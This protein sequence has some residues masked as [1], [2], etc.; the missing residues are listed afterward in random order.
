MKKTA[1]VMIAFVLGFHHIVMEALYL[2][3]VNPLTKYYHSYVSFYMEPLFEQHWQLFAPEPALYSLKFWT[4]CGKGKLKT[5][6]WFDPSEKYLKRHRAWRFGPNGKILYIYNGIARGY[7]NATID[8]TQELCKEGEQGS[9]TCQR[10]VRN[11]IKNN[12]YFKAGKS[13][14]IRE[15]QDY[16]SYRDNFHSFDW[17]QFQAIKIYPK[18]FSEKNSA[19]DF[20]RIEY[21]DSEKI[22]VAGELVSKKY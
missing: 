21:L 9:K 12:R 5:T 6:E 3:P 19:T 13:L 18:Q 11:E 14:A 10:L 16:L 20:G 8:L 7:L 15:C 1:I 2:L 4:R 22:G 17:V